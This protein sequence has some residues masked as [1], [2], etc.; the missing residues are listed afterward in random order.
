[1]LMTF[2]SYDLSLPKLLQWWCA[3]A[4]FCT[5]LHGEC[6]LYSSGNETDNINSPYRSLP[7]STH[8]LSTQDL[9]IQSLCR[10]K[11]M[12]RSPS[13][14]QATGDLPMCLTTPWIPLSAR[15]MSSKLQDVRLTAW[16]LQRASSYSYSWELKHIRQQKSTL[17]MGK[18]YQRQQVSSMLMWH[19]ELCPTHCSS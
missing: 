5:S 19:E 12:M 6:T 15:T 2:H 13:L 8:C 17:E 14:H 3:G 18:R 7:S 9:T 11:R 4:I 16:K 10:Q 1:M